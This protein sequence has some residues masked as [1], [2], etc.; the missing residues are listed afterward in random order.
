M[1][2][3]DFAKPAKFRIDETVFTTPTE[4]GDQYNV[5]WSATSVVGKTAGP[6]SS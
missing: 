2:L 1:T 3:I 4:L 5:V 6:R